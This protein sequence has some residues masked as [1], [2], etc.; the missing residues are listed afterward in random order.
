MSCTLMCRTYSQRV[1]PATIVEIVVFPLAVILLVYVL[2]RMQTRP[3]RDHALNNPVPG[4]EVGSAARI[5]DAGSIGWPSLLDALSVRVAPDSD[6]RDPGPENSVAEMLGLKAPTV[7]GRFQPNL[8]Y[9]TRHDRQ[10][11]VRIGIDETYLSGF[12]TRH[13][14]Q[15]TVLRVDVPDFEL[16][17]KDGV[18]RAESDVPAAL[19]AVLQ[20]LRPSPDVWDGLLVVGG[21]EGIVASRPVPRRVR[22]QFQWLYDLWLVERIA[23]SLRAPALPAARLGRSYLVPYWLGRA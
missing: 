1:H 9:G 6:D 16:V 2:L 8:I 14:R 17:D 20:A 19:G 15:I 3:I 12:S 13:M 11:F 5:T 21:P 4:I 18:V 10:V 22:V 7:I 23:D